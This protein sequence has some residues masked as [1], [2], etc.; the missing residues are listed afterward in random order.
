MATIQEE[1]STAND[2]YWSL[3][4]RQYAFA[5]TLVVGTILAS[6]VAGIGGIGEKL[7]QITLGI[8]ALIPAASSLAASVLKPQGRANWHYRKR[9]RAQALYRRLANEHADP[10]QISAE[11]STIEAE[12][13]K[14]WERDFTLEPSLL[15]GAPMPN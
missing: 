10:A 13:D 11:W 1:L 2:R 4:R 9:A 12:M 5:Y 14:E 15:P 6:A 8:L 7:G 3:A